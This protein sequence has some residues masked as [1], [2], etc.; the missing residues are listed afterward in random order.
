MSGM[1]RTGSW[2][3]T[4]ALLL[5]SMADAMATWEPETGNRLQARAAA[6]TEKIHREVERS[7]PYFEDAYAYAVWPGVVCVALGFGGAYGKG[8]VVEQGSAVGTVG[9]W[10]LSSGIQGGAKSFAMIIFFKDKDTLDGLKRGDLQFTGKAAV[11][12]GT[13]GAAGTPA[14]NDGVAII[15][16]TNL[17]LMLEFSAAGS[18]FNYKPYKQDGKPDE[19]DA[20]SAP[21][22]SSN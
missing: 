5:A 7:H 10:Q 19:A 1:H 13:F 2:V 11:N 20:E 9:L 14:Y 16:V 6:A 3:V 4:L 18:K 8:V 15:P 12:I 22:A 17:G 21:G